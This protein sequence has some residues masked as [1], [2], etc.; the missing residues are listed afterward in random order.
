MMR[1]FSCILFLSVFVFTSCNTSKKILYLQDVRND[2]PVSTTKG[3]QITIMPKDQLSIVVS[4]K[5]PE[6][7]A[8]FNLPRIS[9]QAGVQN[10]SLNSN[11]N[12]QLL[13]YT[14]DVDGK[15]EFPLLGVLSVEGLT[16][17]QLSQMIKERLIK[18]DL[19]KDPIVTVDFMNLHISI[20]GEVQKPGDIRVSRDQVTLFEALS[21]AGDL[22]I[23]GKRDGVYVIREED[24][25]RTKYHVD[26]RSADLYKSP[27]YYLKQNDI[28]YV[29]PN[30]VRA[31]QSTINE[32]NLKSVSLWISITSFLTTVG[33]LVF[34]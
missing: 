17:K 3:A 5:D 10:L 7:A 22:T 29:E 9:H 24:N 32:N 2:V 23:F 28:V 20:L 4:C 34:K 25:T 33:I 11:T 27:A 6:I 31:G 30:K 19:V 13:G 8:L 21:L 15:I 18:E 14:V 16:R 1:L 12:T 26:L